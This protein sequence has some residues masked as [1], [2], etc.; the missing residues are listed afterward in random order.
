MIAPD[1]PG[2]YRLYIRPLVEG[3]TWMEDAGVYWQVTVLGADGTA[4]AGRVSSRVPAP[5]EDTSPGWAPADFNNVGLAQ[6]PA[7]GHPGRQ[8]AG[9]DRRED[10]L[11]GQPGASLPGPGHRLPLQQRGEEVELL[12]EQHLVS[13]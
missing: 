11:I 5:I 4:P 13:P 12:L 1:R 2:F 3:A 10:Q 9:L 6:P 8:R 7:D